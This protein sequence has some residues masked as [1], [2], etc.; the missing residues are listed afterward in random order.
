MPVFRRCKINLETFIN[1]LFFLVTKISIFAD[2]KRTW[3]VRLSVRT[4]GFHPGKRGSIPLRATLI[5]PENVVN[6]RFQVF[7][8]LSSNTGVTKV[9]KPVL[10]FLITTM[11]ESFRPLYRNLQDF[12]DTSF[13]ML[14]Y[15][16]TD[17]STNPNFTEFA[18]QEG[19]LWYGG[20]SA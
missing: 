4:P 10:F 5:E 16:E 1:K 12:V 8:C 11:E 7:L 15:A 6:Q 18:Q 20:F 14:E 13:R 17:F 19:K 9:S 2:P 3:P